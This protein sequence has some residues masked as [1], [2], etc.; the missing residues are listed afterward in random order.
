MQYGF[1]LIEVTLNSRST[2]TKENM[3]IFTR[4][5][6]VNDGRCMK[7]IE[8]VAA[9][10]L[11]NNKIYCAR[12]ADIGEVGLKWEFPGGKVEKGEVAES[13][14]V[15]EIKEELN[16]TVEVDK[17]FMTVEHQYNTFFITLHSYLCTIKEGTLRRNEHVEDKWLKIDELNCLDWAEAD[18]PIV[19]KLMNS[20]QQ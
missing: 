6:K 11:E 16:A 14:L 17:Y 9:I 8:V 18:K 20:I 12:R 7:K 4:K 2:K 15:R 19:E 5:V 13:A 3:L 10:I 1:L